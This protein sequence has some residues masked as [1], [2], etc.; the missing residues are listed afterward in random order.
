MLQGLLLMST[1]LWWTGFPSPQRIVLGLREEGRRGKVAES[2][3][4]ALPLPA[5]M[6]HWAKWDD[7]SLLLNIK[8]EAIMVTNYS[9]LIIIL[10]T[11]VHTKDG[12]AGPNHYLGSQLICMVGLGILLW[13][14]LG[15]ETQ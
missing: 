8:R 12:F 14:V 3:G 6:N 15:L 10:F 5:N 11:S 9:C 13:V 1:P 2:V 4:E 7:E